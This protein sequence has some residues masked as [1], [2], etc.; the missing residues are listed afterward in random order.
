MIYNQLYGL[1]VRRI[2]NVGVFTL[3]ASS[4]TLPCQLTGG[5]SCPTMICPN[6]AVNYTC[7]VGSFAGNTLWN[8][9]SVG[10]CSG[11]TLLLAQGPP[12]SGLSCLT[13]SSSGS[14][15]PFT[16]TNTPPLTSN[17]YCLTSTLS[18][19]VT[20]AMNG[21]VV[22]C[23]SYS[24]ISF[25]TTP[26]GNAAISVVAPPSAPTITSL[27]S[28]YSDQ[29][30]VTWISVPTAT[31][32]N[33]SIND[34]VNT[35]VPIPSTGAP[36][37]MWNIT[38]LTNNTVYTVSVVAINCAG[39]SSPATIHVRTANGPPVPPSLPS[40]TTP[41]PSTTTCPSVL[42]AGP[43]TAAVGSS[44]GTAVGV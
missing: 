37:Y 18:V 8:V 36:Q 42:V 14:C 10:V 24:P 40:T 12:G 32:Y 27:I 31:S 34:S 39:S 15:G 38:G 4:L 3:Q 26:V 21:L 20:S 17:V 43:C 30:T 29:L 44:I 19:V 41:T 7:N 2:Y 16:M 11:T 33:V 35:L 25:T 6:T 9:P 5:T 13:S 23:S 28:T 1:C 22:S